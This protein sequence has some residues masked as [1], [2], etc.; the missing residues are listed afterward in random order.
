[1]R[2]TWRRCTAYENAADFRPGLYLFEWDGQQFY[3]GKIQKSVFGG[4][5]R[6][7]DG[8]QRNPRYALGYKHLI[9]GALRHGGRLYTGTIEGLDEYIGL[10]GVEEYLIREFPTPLNESQ[11]GSQALDIEHI[12]D[13]PECIRFRVR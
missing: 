10:G 5:A 3:W 6:E 12:G 1:M 7:I 4:A 11:G 8:I 9:E 2:I 13:V